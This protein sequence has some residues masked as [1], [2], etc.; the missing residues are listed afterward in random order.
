ML[1]Y[2]NLSIFE[3]KQNNLSPA[4]RHSRRR[5]RKLSVKAD[6]PS[7][8]LTTDNVGACAWNECKLSYRHEKMQNHYGHQLWSQINALIKRIQTLSWSEI[9]SS[10]SSAILILKHRQLFS[11]IRDETSCSWNINNFFSP[12]FEWLYFWLKIFCVLSKS[13]SLLLF[14]LT[15][16]VDVRIPRTATLPIALLRTRKWQAYD[17]QRA[18]ACFCS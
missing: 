9:G 6:R 2:C 1:Q 10:K 7:P 12:I 5:R 3:L 16:Q 13:I 15:L 14:I 8:F 11:P 18:L 17:P 4:S